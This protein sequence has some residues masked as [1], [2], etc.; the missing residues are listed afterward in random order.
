[1]KFQKVSV[2]CE[3]DSDERCKDGDLA[4]GIG[5]SGSLLIPLLKHSIISF[6]GSKKLSTARHLKLT[7]YLETRQPLSKKCGGS[8]H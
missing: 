5:H 2:S 3:I 1:M 4:P 6:Q 7:M 8:R